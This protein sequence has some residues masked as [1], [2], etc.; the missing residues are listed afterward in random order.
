MSSSR[1]LVLYGS[2]TG[3]AQDF[4]TILSTKLR[5]L[6]F[7]NTLS[8]LG[9]LPP[10][11]ILKA[12]YVFLLVSTTGQGELPRNVH[13]S[14]T[15]NQK[16]LWSLLKKKHIEKDFLIHLK[17]AFFGLGDSCYPKFNYGVRKLHARFVDQLG[18]QEIFDRLEADEQGM[19]GSN[20]GTG[21]G[22]ESVYFEFEKRVISYLMEKFPTR[23]V[24]SGE[25]IP[26]TEI[27]RATFLEPKSFLKV[28]SDGATV[29]KKDIVFEGD[30]SIHWGEVVRNERITASDHFQDVRDFG[31]VN[32]D[33][34]ADPVKYYP[35]DTAAIYPCNSD[36]EVER[37]LENQTHWRPH[38][39]KE[40]TFT[41][42]IP[43]GLRGIS[44]GIVQ[45]LT[46]R[47]L[48]K[49]HLDIMSIPRSSFFMKI[50]TFATDVS[51]MERGAEQL[52]DQREKLREFGYDEDMQELFDYC[53][54]PRRS[55]V[56]VLDDFLSVRLPWEYCLDY[57]PIIKPRYYSIS[58]GACSPEVRLTVAVVQYRTVLRHIR[59]GVCTTY[60]SGLRSGDTL[61]YKINENR[62]LSSDLDGPP[63]ILVG[64]G[65]GIAPIMSLLRTHPS[66]LPP[67]KTHVYFGCR[68]KDKDYLFEEELE[69]LSHNGSILLHPVFSRDRE[70]SPTTKYVQDVLWEMGE[71]LTQ[72]LVSE[73]GLFYLCGSSGKMP[74]QVR[75]TLV[76]MLKR[77]GG[78]KDD[79]SATDFLKEMERNGRYLQETW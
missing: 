25:S 6:H 26:R 58:S 27:D 47:N 5:R 72:L 28:S 14:A 19:A 66:P 35:G 34:T 2:E 69:G 40:L 57:F 77:W 60:M 13:E 9:D 43:E 21:L 53:N 51:R 44:G 23:R 18:A 74:L 70:N 75:L 76:E 56:E 17:V 71:E 62:L 1:I 10:E 48:L 37:F 30:S 3:N 64:P 33:S 32:S 65:V 50:W 46:L 41:N 8:S 54:R 31:F 45:P 16:T 61:R 20:K 73:Q 42:G 15:R 78:F 39:D 38:V 55:V 11:A 7:A 68:I 63:L 67:G 12:R 29:T 24:A 79:Q 4:A 22:V 36:T 49:Y 52:T 59:R